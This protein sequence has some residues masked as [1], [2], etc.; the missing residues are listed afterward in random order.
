M[1]RVLFLGEINVDLILGGLESFPIPDREVACVSFEKTIG[2]STAICAC[3]YSSLGGDTYFLGLAGKDEYG[4]FMIN[5]MEDFGINTSLVKR[6]SRIGTGVTV[7]LIH[8][9]NRTQ[10]TYPGTIGE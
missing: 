8:D 5:G 3:A 7:N 10:V 4:D 2:S 9:K 6:T 1:K